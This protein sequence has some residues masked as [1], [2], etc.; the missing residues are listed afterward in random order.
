MPLDLARLNLAETR[1]GVAQAFGVGRRQEQD[2]LARR[3]TRHQHQRGASLLKTRQV[4]EI[5]VLSIL[6]VDVGGIG[7]RR[8]A[9]DDEQALRP[10]LFRQTRAPRP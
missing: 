10:E 9:L 8:P 4:I 3:I 7:S 1:T 6:V 5:A 2:L